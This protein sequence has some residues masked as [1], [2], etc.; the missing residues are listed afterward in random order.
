MFQGKNASP[1][2]WATQLFPLGHKTFLEKLSIPIF[3]AWIFQAGRGASLVG[4]RKLQVSILWV[5][6]FILDFFII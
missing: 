2:I 6:N 5:G 1:N 4:D 3:A